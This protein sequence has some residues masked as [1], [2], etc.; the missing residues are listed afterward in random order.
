MKKHVRFGP[1]TIHPMIV[2]RYAYHE[3]RKG[4]WER[5]ALDRYRFHHRIQ[6]I[7]KVLTPVLLHKM[8]SGPL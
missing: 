7:E 8:L 4:P 1:V 3:A 5:Y 6:E 2:W